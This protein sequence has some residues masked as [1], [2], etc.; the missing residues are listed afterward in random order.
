MHDVW[1][2]RYS[3]IGFLSRETQRTRVREREGARSEKENKAK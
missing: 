1:I 3:F 2:M